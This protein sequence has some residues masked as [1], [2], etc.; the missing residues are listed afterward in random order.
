MPSRA[1]AGNGD[2]FMP[3][4]DFRRSL[5]QSRFYDEAM[6]L[7]IVVYSFYVLIRD[8]IAFFEQVAQD[9]ALL[10]QPD[11]GAI[12]ATLARISQWMFVAL[13]AVLPLFRHRPIA[14]S[15]QLL[16]RL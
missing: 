4:S 15:A 10:A 12:V 2:Y 6:R 3:L 7:P 1:I 8:V 14:K 9:P 16:P 11:G 5:E 13:L